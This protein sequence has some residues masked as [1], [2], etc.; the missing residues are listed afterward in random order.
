MGSDGVSVDKHGQVGS[1][2]EKFFADALR[3]KLLRADQPPNGAR[4][5]AQSRGYLTGS[6]VHPVSLGRHNVCSSPS[7]AEV[8]D[9]SG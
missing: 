9:L 7:T 8:T 1:P 4:A 2:D 3:R 5:D 6:E